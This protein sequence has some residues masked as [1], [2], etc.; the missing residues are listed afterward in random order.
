MPQINFRYI[1]NELK[2]KASVLSGTGAP[3]SSPIYA[4]ANAPAGKTLYEQTDTDPR[5]LWFKASDD[6]WLEVGSGG[7]GG[8]GNIIPWDMTPTTVPAVTYP[9]DAD[10][11]ELITLAEYQGITAKCTM[12]TPQNARATVTADWSTSKH[13]GATPAAATAVDVDFTTGKKAIGFRYTLPSMDAATSGAAAN[14]VLS[15]RSIGWGSTLVI[16]ADYS[17]GQWESGLGPVLVDNDLI[18]M[19]VDAVA[20]TV[21]FFHNG[22]PLYSDYT[23]YPADTYFSVVIGG[24]GVQASDIGKIIGID[25]IT[26][27]SELGTLPEGTTDIYG[28]ADAD[29]PLGATAGS[30]LEVT[31]AGTYETVPYSVGDVAVVLTDGTTVLKLAP[32]DEPGGILSITG[33]DGIVIDSSDPQNPVISSTSVL[34]ASVPLIAYGTNSAGNEQMNYKSHVTQSVSVAPSKNVVSI[35]CESAIDRTTKVFLNDNVTSWNFYSRPPVGMYYELDVYII[36]GATPKTCVSPATAG[37]TAGG[38]WTVSGVANSVQRLTLKV[39]DSTVE[40]YPHP[41]LS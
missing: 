6:T 25:V 20:G 41:V 13:Y 28:N 34:K 16:E 36:Q 1:L 17:S 9:L 27:L 37:H 3:A 30:L 14:V 31:V 40:L 2:A 18:V 24:S 5:K 33:V 32:E 21:S 15:S 38:A 22:A 10:E 35:Y 11:A 23:S 39:T 12:L 4:V 19:V 7:G 26:D 8:G 29:L